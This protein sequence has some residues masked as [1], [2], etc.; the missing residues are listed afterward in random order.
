MFPEKKHFLIRPKSLSQK[1]R[2][3]WIEIL[4]NMKNTGQKFVIISGAGPDDPSMS[5]A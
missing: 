1:Y 2:M 4:A 5:Q 3:K